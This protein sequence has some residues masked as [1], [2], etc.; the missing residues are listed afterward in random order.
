[1]LNEGL[2]VD[3]RLS[4]HRL[5]SILSRVDDVCDLGGFPSFGPRVLK[6]REFSYSL[7]IFEKNRLCKAV[8]TAHVSPARLLQGN[9]VG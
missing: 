6:A 2:H 9:T 7:L 3:S 5:I 8:V 1:M 4:Y